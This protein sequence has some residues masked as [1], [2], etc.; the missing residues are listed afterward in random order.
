MAFSTSAK[1]RLSSLSSWAGR[2]C[3]P[4][5]DRQQIHDCVA[6]RVAPA[7]GAV[8]AQ[9]IHHCFRACEGLCRIVKKASAAGIQPVTDQDDGSA[10]TGF[11]AQFVGGVNESSD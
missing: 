11:A 9:R 3:P 2:M 8:G 10:G 7:V 1:A 6:L 5:G 4:E